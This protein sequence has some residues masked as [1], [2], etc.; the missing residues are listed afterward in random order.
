[1]G[2]LRQQWMEDYAQVQQGRSEPVSPAEQRR[3]AD[4]YGYYLKGWLPR[5]L[6]LPVLDVGCGAGLFMAMLG[7]AKFTEVAGI[8]AS[9][10]QAALA[11]RLSLQ[12][13]EGDALTYLQGKK[14]VYGLITAFD[15]IEHLS[16][17]QALQFLEVCLQALIPGGRLILQT[18][19][20]ES[21]WV[22][23]VLYGDPTHQQCFTPHLLEKMMRHAGY[24]DL[25]ARPCGPAPVDIITAL[26]H[27]AWS[28]ITL[29]CRLLNAI[30]GAVSSGIHTRVFLISGL[31]PMEFGRPSE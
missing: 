24:A 16:P 4:I 11:R 19:N 6:S 12:V 5:D 2:T 9:P 10:S 7:R 29:G 17:D 30:E 13:E 22:G 27:W 31:R 26:R 18:P 23:N 1:M 25:E 14:A 8:E 20:G 3:F 28:G 21:P 15:L